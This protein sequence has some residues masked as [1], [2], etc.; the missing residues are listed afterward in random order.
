M[1]RTIH[2]RCTSSWPTSFLIPD[3]DSVGIETVPD[4][5]VT[6]RDVYEKPEFNGKAKISY[7]YDLGEI[8]THDL[9]LIGRA[10]PDQN[11]Q[12]KAPDEISVICLAGEG[13]PL[14]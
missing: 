6:L 8:W 4:K 10:V 14:E 11:A 3:R 2:Q 12:M 9:A 7:T 1:T 13:H 5:D